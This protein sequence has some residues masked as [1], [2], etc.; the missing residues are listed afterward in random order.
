MGRVGVGC[1]S[2]HLAEVDQSR[3]S[4]RLVLASATRSEEES[5]S[6]VVVK[7]R[8]REMN[9]AAFRLCRIGLTT[10]PPML[11]KFGNP[12]IQVG[13]RSSVGEGGAIEIAQVPCCRLCV[14]RLYIIDDTELRAM[15]IPRRARV[16]NLCVNVG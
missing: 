5:L 8:S 3:Q 10:N 12:N 9:G 15:M 7:K 11:A 13:K 14:H 2:V 6:R 4:S 1:T 16:L